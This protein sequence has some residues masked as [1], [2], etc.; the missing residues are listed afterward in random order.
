MTARKEKRPKPEQ[1]SLGIAITDPDKARRQ[2]ARK[3]RKCLS[4][5]NAFAS[6]WAGN[7]ICGRCKDT[8]SYS[9]P[10]DFSLSTAAF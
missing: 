1:F 6:E 10:A 3:T 2:A 7:R 4:C 8:V 9:R 5:S